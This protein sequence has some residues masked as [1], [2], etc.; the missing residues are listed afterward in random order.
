MD[1]AISPP[2]WLDAIGKAEWQRLA[3][4]LVRT[5]LLT[6]LDTTALAAYCQAFST[7]REA[8]DKLRK[9][10]MV[11]KAGNGFPMQSPYVSIAHQQMATMRALLVEF[12]LT[13]SSR[14][15]ATRTPAP[16]AV[17]PLEQFLTRKPKWPDQP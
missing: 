14:A 9:F 5:G 17:N 6:E 12:G 16:V 13:P 8:T 4:M 11:I 1:E 15:S 2:E 7:W 10:G 3:P